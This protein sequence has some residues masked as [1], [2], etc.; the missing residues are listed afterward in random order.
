MSLANSVRGAHADRMVGDVSVLVDAAVRGPSV[1]GNELGFAKKRTSGGF[2][3]HCCVG[4]CV[5]WWHPRYIFRT[6][7]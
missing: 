7:Y 4:S 2:T 6:C 5:F 1:C 3:W